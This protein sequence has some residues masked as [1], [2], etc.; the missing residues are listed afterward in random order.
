[1]FVKKT[2]GYVIANNPSRTTKFLQTL[3]VDWLADENVHFLNWMVVED[4]KLCV[5]CKKMRGKVYERHQ[6]VFPLPPLHPHCRCTIQPIQTA[7]AGT[8]T[9]DRND[10]ADWWLKNQGKLPD[11]YITYQGAKALGY[12]PKKG[13]LNE[14]APGKMITRGQ[15]FNRNGHL[16]EKPGRIWCE[17]DIYYSGG[18]R[19]SERI[20]YSNDGLIFI[21]LD[22]YITFIEII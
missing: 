4:E 8:T 1:M 22:H 6:L 9:N 18:Y 5:E 16:P 2:S 21:T 14:V 11:Y 20:L 17:A 10:G 3:F 19:N 12:K 7:K 15:Y 13:N